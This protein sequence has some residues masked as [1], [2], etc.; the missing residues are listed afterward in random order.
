MMGYMLCVMS[1]F[2]PLF[3]FL[4]LFLRP[5]LIILVFIAAALL[6]EPSALRFTALIVCVHKKN[7]FSVFVSK[8]K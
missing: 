4:I 2:H 7:K 5:V 6:S 3:V 8:A 1:L